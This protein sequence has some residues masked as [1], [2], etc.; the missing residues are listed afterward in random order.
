[1]ILP[2]SFE[3]IT[4]LIAVTSIILLVTSELLSP[5][6]GKINII[7]DKKKL[8]N[9]AIVATMLFLLTLILRILSLLFNF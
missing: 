6:Y 9:S 1:M 2:L 7:I 5:R 4:L 8:R 3:D